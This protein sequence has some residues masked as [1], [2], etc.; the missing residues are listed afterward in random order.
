MS[1]GFLLPGNFLFGAARNKDSRKL[2]LSTQTRRRKFPVSEQ[3]KLLGARATGGAET[4]R[5]S[6]R[7]WRGFG[8][9]ALFRARFVYRGEEV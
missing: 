7:S 5:H 6:L 8:L 1:W 2:Q 4:G 3:E 9:G